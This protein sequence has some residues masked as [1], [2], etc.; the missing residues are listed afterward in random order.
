MPVFNRLDE[1]RN[2]KSRKIII[3]DL[4]GTL[5]ESKKDMDAEMSDLI[6]NLLE[7]R[8]FAVIGGGRYEQFKNQFIKNLPHKP[9]RLSRLYIFPTCATALYRFENNE[10]RQVYAENLTEQEIEMIRGAFEKALKQADFQKPETLYG[11]MIEDRGTQ[12]TFSALGQRA[13]I[14]L[15]SKWD[16]DQKKRML[17]K[18]HLAPLLPGFEINLGG[19]TS[20]DVTR[21]GINKAYGI[22]KIKEYCGYD[23]GEM[24][25]IGDAL[26]EGGNDHPVVETGVDCLQVSGPEE[27]KRIIKQLIEAIKEVQ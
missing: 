9:D 22:R 21:R 7:Y 1:I 27:T 2:Y 24:L 18:S 10:W 11:E 23:F 26:F 17:I 3:A 12:V 25:F 20:M 5:T 16:P 14:E 13:P 4:D 15:K 19:M 6:M 8:D